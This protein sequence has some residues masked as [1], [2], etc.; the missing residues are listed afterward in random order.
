MSERYMDWY[1]TLGSTRHVGLYKCKCIALP[2]RWRHAFICMFIHL[3]AHKTSIQCM[4]MYFG[5][6]Y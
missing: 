2:A 6:Y 3:D 4:V 1:A 5:G